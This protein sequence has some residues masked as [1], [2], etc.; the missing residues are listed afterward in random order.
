MLE[1]PRLDDDLIIECLRD[2]YG[3]TVTTLTFL[4]LGYDAYAGVYRVTT[5]TEQ[6]YFLKIKQSVLYE[7]S[8]RLPRFLKDHGLEQIAAPL[9]TR[10]GQEW[11]H[12][13][14]FTVILYPFI[15]GTNGLDTGLSDAQWIE[16]G[17][18][19]RQLHD[20]QL[21]TELAT[22]IRG[23]T[24]ASTWSETIEHIRTLIHSDHID[25][26]ARDLAT[27]W[28][29]KEAE[30]DLIFARADSLGR[31]LQ[32]RSLDFVLCHADIHIGNV[33]L[34]TDGRVFIVDWDQPLFAPKERD[35]VFI[36]G[37]AL[38]NVGKHEED[39]FLQGYG[40]TQVDEMT[41]AYYRYDWMV[42]D[43]GEYGKQVFLQED[44]SATVKQDATRIFTSLFGPNNG[45]ESAHRL[46]HLINTWE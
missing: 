23:E 15:E 9:L 38:G 7:A 8:V 12:I 14:D 10:S 34:R 29:E 43:I 36:L 30:I 33:L 16:F 44:V 1:K 39:L 20:M 35:F 27:F 22:Q 21:P 28:R 41:L 45:V 37:A 25:P 3:L 19:L 4:P 31:R 2:D 46:D 6:T 26:A 5:D 42:Q 32:T 24:F 13:D 17:T 11:T 18:A 40:P